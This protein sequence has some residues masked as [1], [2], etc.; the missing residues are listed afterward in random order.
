MKRTRRSHGA[1]CK[2]PVVLV[3]VKGD[4][5]LAELPEQCRGHS[6]RITEEKQQLLA[7]AADVLG[8]SKPPLD[9]PDLKT[10]HAKIGQLALEHDC[11]DGAL[12]KAGWLSA[13]RG[14]PEPTRDPSHDNASCSS[15]P[16]PPRTT[17]PHLYCRRTSL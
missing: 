11:L 17:T 13:Q 8:G 14:L 15:W 5:T 1:A 4:Q 9:T 2:A 6:P 16:G 12:I 3:A 10:L 7:R